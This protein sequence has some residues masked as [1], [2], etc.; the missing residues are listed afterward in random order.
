M[1]ERLKHL[2]IGHPIIKLME[3]FGFYNEYIFNKVIFNYHF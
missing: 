2:D 1:S 3:C